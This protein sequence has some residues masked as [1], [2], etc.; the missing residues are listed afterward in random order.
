VLE[1]L[2]KELESQGT[3]AILR[4]G[5]KMVGLGEKRLTMAQFKPA[6]AVNPDTLARYAANRL[7]VVEEV[8]Y[9]QHNGNRL[10]LVFF[11]NGLPI[12]TAELKTDSTQSVH[13]AIKQ[14]RKDRPPVDPVA[15]VSEP[16]LAFKSRCVVHFAVSTS[17][18]AMAT[19]LEG[20]PTV[21][22]PF[23]LGFN[24]GSGNPP[25]ANGCRTAYLWERVLQRDAWLHILGGFVHLE[26][27]Q[28]KQPDGRK[29]TV[30][31]LIFPRFHQWDAVLKLVEAARTE[32]AGKTYLVQHSAGSGK[33]NTIAWTAHHLASLHDA[34][35]KKVFDSVIVITD[36][37]VLDQQLQ[38]TIFQFEHKAGVRGRLNDE[39]GAK[40]EK[41]AAALLARKPIIIVTI[42]TFGFVLKR[43]QTE[44][45]LRGRNFAVIAD[46]AHSSQSGRAAAE[47][48]KVLGKDA[49]KV[50]DD[51]AEV[52]FEDLLGAD[53]KARTRP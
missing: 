38:D 27:K 37:T 17:E 26:R 2:V 51:E 11:V 8:H 48:K 20:L 47:L 5:F 46:E 35:D 40:S 31:S 13:D 15:K 29:V 16:L 43:I 10:D 7:R 21:F 18:V 14:Y 53:V 25:N 36:R 49:V 30:E 19:R 34:N 12:S 44:E 1:R 24:E 45:A 23:N 3:L 22:R 32:G 6:F 50:E 41:L 52:T 28:K 4:H 9:S 42:Q 39:D 33:S